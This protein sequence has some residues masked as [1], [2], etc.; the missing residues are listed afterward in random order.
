MADNFGLVLLSIR[1]VFQNIIT[2]LKKNIFLFSDDIFTHRPNTYSN[3]K[4]KK[5]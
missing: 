4:Q 1:M 2:E 3:T 5:P